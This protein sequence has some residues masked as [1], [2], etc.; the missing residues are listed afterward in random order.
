LATYIRRA[1]RAVKLKISLDTARSRAIIAE[2]LSALSVLAK[3]TGTYTLIFVFGDG[4]EL[5]LGNT[6][7]SD[8]DRFDW[9]ISELRMT[10]TAQAGVTA[11]FIG[12]QQVL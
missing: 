1:T 9:D 2:E 7:I 11:T 8:G 12:E 6:E 3:G 5:E 4:T 10:H